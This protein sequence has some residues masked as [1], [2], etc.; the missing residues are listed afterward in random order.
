[1]SLHQ[2]FDMCQ[3]D[4]NFLKWMDFIL[5]ISIKTHWINIFRMFIV[6]AMIEQ[7][8]LHN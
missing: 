7:S 3:S 1:M 2:V 4:I 8:V 5:D 6:K